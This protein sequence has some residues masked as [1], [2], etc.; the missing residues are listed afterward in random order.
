MAKLVEKLLHKL[1]LVR[2]VKVR[3]VVTAAA[4]GPLVTAHRSDLEVFRTVAGDAI[5]AARYFA[6]RQN[7]PCEISAKTATEL[8]NVLL[9]AGNL[10]NEAAT[11]SER[12]F[13]AATLPTQ[14]EDAQ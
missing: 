1:G 9:N 10:L 14:A 13:V 3:E 5:S 4:Y 2:Y 11:R 8:V 6:D 7:S 12:E